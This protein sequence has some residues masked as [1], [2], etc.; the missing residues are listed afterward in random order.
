MEVDSVASGPEGIPKNLLQAR[1]SR[2]RMYGWKSRT[3][4]LRCSSLRAIQG[5]LALLFDESASFSAPTAFGSY[6]VLHQTG[7]GVLGPVFR[8]FDPRHDRLVAVKVFTLDLFPDTVVRLA[9]ALRR[10]V[11]QPGLHPAIAP[12]VEAGVEGTTPFL[13]MEYQTGETLDVLIRRLAPASMT[14]AKPLL[15]SVAAA[16]DQ[17]GPRWDASRIAQST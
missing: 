3:G 6:R 2:R 5:G 7:S 17:R 1:D 9:D 14:V 8:A 15:S 10:L 11:S 12:V 13:V 4:V 16:I